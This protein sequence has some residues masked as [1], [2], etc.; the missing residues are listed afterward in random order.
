MPTPH[1]HAVNPKRAGKLCGATAGAGTDHLGIGACWRHLGNMPTHRKHA[2][3]VLAEQTREDLTRRLVDRLAAGQRPQI[4]LVAATEANLEIGEQLVAWLVDD[5]L[6]EAGAFEAT[7]RP[8]VWFERLARQVSEQLGA[9][10]RASQL[11]IE[12]RKATALEVYGTEIAALLRSIREA[13][14]A[15]AVEAFDA[16]AKPGLL[17]LGGAIE[18]TS[19]EATPEREDGAQ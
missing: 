2:A 16:V 18:A 12:D 13:L 1:C 6:P 11:G 17:A 4:D 8:S 14:P 7:G 9:L 19:T 10:G 15:D 5:V 3:T